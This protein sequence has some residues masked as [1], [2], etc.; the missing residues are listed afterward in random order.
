MRFQISLFW[1]WIK[2]I[3]WPCT[4]YTLEILK[5]APSKLSHSQSY[6]RWYQTFALRSFNILIS[7]SSQIPNRDTKYEI[8]IPSTDTKYEIHKEIQI[9]SRFTDWAGQQY[10]LIFLSLV[11]LS[12]ISLTNGMDAVALLIAI[13]KRG[14]YQRKEGF[15]KGKNTKER[16]DF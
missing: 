14:K 11:D 13:S 8:L 10:I 3:Q 9:Q 5:D 4:V 15:V 12:A 7:I 6:P 1:G 2:S 16:R